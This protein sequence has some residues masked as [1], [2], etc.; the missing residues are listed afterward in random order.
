MI[1]QSFVSQSAPRRQKI[2]GSR[3]LMC[4][5]LAERMMTDHASQTS[6]EGILAHLIWR[7]L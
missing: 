4:R 2:V 1:V 3:C 7:D 5:Q 6:M